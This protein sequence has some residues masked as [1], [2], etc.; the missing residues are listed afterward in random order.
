MWLK[1]IQIRNTKGFVDSG[2]IEFSQGI[3][4]LVGTN[5][6]GK[7]TVLRSIQ[8]LQPTNEL[9]A[10]F[11]NFLHIGTSPSLVSLELADVTTQI[12]IPS[13]KQNVPNFDEK[14]WKPK[15]NFSSTN[16]EQFRASIENPITKAKE[17]LPAELCQPN[18]P[19]NFIY[20]YFSR[21]KTIQFQYQI[22]NN[23]A[24][25]VE[26]TFQHLPSKID[27][28]LTLDSGFVEPFIETCN[29]ILGIKVSCV[30]FGGGKN[31]GLRLK[32]GRLLPIE[33]MGE[34][35]LHILFFLARLCSATGK[36]FLIEEIETDLHPKALKSLLEF[37]I[38]K[39]QS[40]QFIVTT[41][42]NIVVRYL[43]GAPKSKVFSLEMK[44]E[45]P[46]KIPICTCQPVPDEPDKR[47]SLLENLGYDVFDSF[48]WKGYL[49]LEESTAERVICEVL[50][51]NFY[52]SLLTK[53]RT[54]AA[55]GVQNVEPCFNDFHRLFVFVHTSP[56]YKERA[57]VIVDGNTEGKNIIERL[58]EK[59]NKEWPDNHF[60][61]FSAEQFEK[62]YPKRFGQQVADVLA[63]PHGKRKQDAK[64]ELAVSVVNWALNDP[65]AAK[66]EFQESA[67]EVLR[68][69]GEIE[70][71]LT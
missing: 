50:I 47:I 64:G 58:K 40:N 51:P 65:V 43:G 36:L 52:P 54:I 41:H 10:F 23:H 32:S 55:R 15:I 18:E 26:E 13:V 22:N 44:L 24:R 38:D 53:L 17:N 45:E 71:K 67:S 46:S 8:L 56:A 21:R 2:A 29:K 69:L 66:V 70:T 6:A 14:S 42:N 20:P 62:Y 3:N 30:Q 37:I 12:A 5:N 11:N 34:G 63:M 33:N 9:H 49:I 16:N 19:S 48:L 25:L 1:S 60:R 68:F 4:V 59:F 7:S 28:L 35:I 39:S 57:W 61:S 27:E 31:V